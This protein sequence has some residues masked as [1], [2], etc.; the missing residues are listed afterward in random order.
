MIKL[1]IN[2]NINPNDLNE[3]KEEKD[4]NLLNQISQDKKDI[5]QI[6][7]NNQEDKKPLTIFKLYQE[8]EIV[9]KTHSRVT[10]ENENENNNINN[11]KTKDEKNKTDENEDDSATE[12]TNEDFIKHIK[13][14]LSSI[15]NALEEN[16][17]EFI[18]FIRDNKKKKKIGKEEYYY[19][20]IED[21]NGFLVGI[22]VILSDLQL[23]CLCSKY[24]LPDELRLINVKTLE[25]SLQELK[26]GIFKI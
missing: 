7:D 2:W 6:S 9:K 18:S 26:D 11:N 25:Q 4:D 3:N 17:L 19:I 1:V 22:E 12:I 15:I 10:N 13:D 14:S 21:L 24:S 20:D 5:P 23:S 8:D 16:S